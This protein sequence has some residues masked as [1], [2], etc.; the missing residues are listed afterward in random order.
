[1]TNLPPTLAR[2]FAASRLTVTGW[3]PYSDGRA[4]IV[5]YEGVPYGSNDP[6]ESV[7]GWR[8]VLEGRINLRMFYIFEEVETDD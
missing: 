4:V 6:L 7:P 3:R 2:A 1:M 5:Y 8:L